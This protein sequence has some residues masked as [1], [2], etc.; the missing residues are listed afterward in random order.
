MKR[1]TSAAVIGVGLLLTAGGRLEAQSYSPLNPRNNPQVSPW[2]N[3]N[4]PFSDPAINYFGIVRPEFA[5]LRTFQQL[6]QGESALSSQQQQLAG[7]V[8][9]VLRPTGHQAGFMTQSRYFQTM[10]ARGTIGGSRPGGG[11]TAPMGGRGPT[12]PAMTSGIRR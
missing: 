10:G 12:T 9:T 5:A 1:L 6:Q 8:G 11:L 3:L 2:I 4:R 7:T